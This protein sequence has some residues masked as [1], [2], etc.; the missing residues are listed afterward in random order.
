MDIRQAV[1][2]AN[3]IF[4]DAQIKGI[5][6]GNK[7]SF[8]NVSFHR[9]KF[10]RSTLF[11]D[12]TFRGSA[13]FGYCSVGGNADFGWATFKG[14]AKFADATVGQHAFFNPA[15]FEKEADF[16]GIKIE[17]NGYFDFDWSVT[18]RVQTK[19]FVAVGDDTLYNPGAIFKQVCTF[20][21]A[22]IGRSAFFDRARFGS[23]A[24]FGNMRVGGQLSFVGAPFDGYTAFDSAKVGGKTLFHGA[25]FKNEVA[26][27]R[28]NF[29]GG[30]Y[31][32]HAVHLD[33]Y[34]RGTLFENR[35]LFNA[36]SLGPEANFDGELA[37][38][39]AY[40][41]DIPENV[42]P[43]TLSDRF[44]GNVDFRGCTYDHVWISSW[45]SILNQQEP[46]DR[47]P[48]VQLERTFHNAG[49]EYRAD[50]VY[51]QRRRL[52]GRQKRGLSKLG[53]LT[54]WGLVGYGVRMRR[55]LYWIA[56]ILVLSTLVF[57]AEGA[58]QAASETGPTLSE[59]CRNAE[60][61][62]LSLSEAFWTGLDAFLPP[63]IN[64]PAGDR[65]EPSPNHSIIIDIGNVEFSTI[66]FA[67]FA[68][69]LQLAGWVIVPVGL[70]G[71]TGILQ[72]VGS[73]KQ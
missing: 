36:A 28:V 68:S 12:T 24:L 59:S 23:N 26:F 46:F 27:V 7:A 54:L 41:H 66:S 42:E 25:H 55:L 73:T 11:R 57:Q 61:C 35:V 67:S 62:Q 17:G 64:L 4:D 14:V 1:F 69:L 71:L 70:A 60:P 45:E 52:E 32:Q 31:F 48:Y 10:R 33:D 15:L 2:A 44:R 39:H 51:Y 38:Y 58:V 37:F 16:T 5:F 72:R 63:P 34:Y 43:Q 30:T 40:T 21:D 8:N 50:A 65:W 53:D 13:I 6:N 20:V 9:T 19:F 47:Q 18:S 22:N 3:L 49:E 56:S 29:Q